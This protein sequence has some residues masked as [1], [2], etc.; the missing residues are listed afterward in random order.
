MSKNT[1]T[2]NFAALGMTFPFDVTALSTIFFGS[3]GIYIGGW[4]DRFPA[5]TLALLSRCVTYLALT[6]LSMSR[7]DCCSNNQ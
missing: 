6:S 2:G 4:L 3:I 5:A 1:M 7:R